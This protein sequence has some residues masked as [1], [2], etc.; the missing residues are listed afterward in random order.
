M[1]DTLNTSSKISKSQKQPNKFSKI[2]V[3]PNKKHIKT[4]I[5]NFSSTKQPLVGIQEDLKATGSTHQVNTTLNNTVVKSKTN[6]A[7]LAENSILSKAIPNLLETEFL[8]NEVC[9]PVSKE[10][11]IGLTGQLADLNSIKSLVLAGVNLGKKSLK[12]RSA[13]NSSV[14]MFLSGNR[15]NSAILKT[16]L[17]LSYFLRAIHILTLIIKAGG[18]VLIIN[19]NPEFSILLKQIRKTTNSSQIFYSDCYWVGGTL[20]NWAQVSKSINTFINFYDKFDDFLMKNQI[21]FTEYKKMRKQFKGFIIEKKAVKSNLLF[22]LDPA[23]NK[24]EI[25]SKLNRILTNTEVG[26]KY[27]LEIRSKLNRILT[28]N[29]VVKHR[30]TKTLFDK[31]WKPDLIFILNSAGTEAIVKEAFILKIP[32]ISLVDSN[33]NI[34]NI[35]YPIPTNKDCFG[36]ARFCLNFILKI[37]SKNE[38]QK[39]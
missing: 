19:T 22:E 18:N 7:Y 31:N 17:M 10:K 21:N 3:I 38:K 27:L 33:T 2:K 8:T 9:F 28:K 32:V 24:S 5:E 15:N 34:S 16:N 39:S 26:N 14:S 20:T 13:W 1:N 29:K 36:L 25:S 37:A 12:D 4:N 6:S 30:Q 35:T 23:V 11:S